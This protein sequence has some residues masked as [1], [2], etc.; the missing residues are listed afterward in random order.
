MYSYFM[1]YHMFKWLVNTP[2]IPSL[3]P[4]ASFTV[5]SLPALMT[6][7]CFLPV[8]V[9]DGMVNEQLF[10]HCCTLSLHV[11]RAVLLLHEHSVRVIK[12]VSIKARIG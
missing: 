10:M 5:A 9:T 6:T 11:S 12:A 2:C 3:P 4:A 1:Y 7:G 8:V